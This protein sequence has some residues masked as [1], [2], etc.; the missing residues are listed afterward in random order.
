LPERN[1]RDPVWLKYFWGN[2][3]RPEKS[4]TLIKDIPNHIWV[5]YRKKAL[6]KGLKV[7]DVAIKLFEKWVKGEIEI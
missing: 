1:G 2:Q 7:N 5:A 6:E 4:S 3:N